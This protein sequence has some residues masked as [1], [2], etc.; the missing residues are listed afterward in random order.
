MKSFSK[1]QLNKILII[2]QVRKEDQS[3]LK[4]EYEKL[5]VEFNLKNFFDDIY[6]Q[7]AISDIIFA[8]CGSST[9]AEIEL[10]KKFSIL[11]PLPNSMDNH[12]KLNAKEFKK[13]I[14]V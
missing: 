12:Q 13:K 4:K 1:I 5:G 9:L 3:K 7:I 2:Q 6:F 11:L 8:R 10:Y 14:N